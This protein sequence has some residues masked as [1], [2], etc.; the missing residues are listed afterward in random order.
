MFFHTG[1]E[2][3]MLFK[4][5]VPRSNVQ[6]L[7]ACLFFIALGVA[8]TGIK[9]WRRSCEERWTA[10]AGSANAGGSGGEPGGRLLA[11]G[12]AG[13]SVRQANLRRAAFTFVT[14]GVMIPIY[15]L[16]L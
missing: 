11:Q 13:P 1:L 14:V 6:Y 2:D 5:W 7:A 10:P 3:Y 8:S 15:I 12:A 16:Y 4:S 9:G